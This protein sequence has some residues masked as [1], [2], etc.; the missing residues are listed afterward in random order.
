MESASRC[1]APHAVRT[2]KSRPPDGRLSAPEDSPEEPQIHGRNSGVTQSS[3]SG[4]C[5]APPTCIRDSHVTVH[6]RRGGAGFAAC[7]QEWFER[8][9][10]RRALLVYVDDWS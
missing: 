1:V 4:F 5:I 6:S 10:E 2:L 8:R 3:T 9:A 7:D